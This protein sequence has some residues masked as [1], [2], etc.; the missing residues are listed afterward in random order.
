MDD[1]QTDDVPLFPT[2]APPVFADPTATRALF[3][4]VMAQL[5]AVVEVDD[6]QLALPS[7]CQAYRV[8]GLRR[9]VLAWL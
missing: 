1:T 9:H 8:A 4:P 3:G 5:A 7:P 6:D 2:T